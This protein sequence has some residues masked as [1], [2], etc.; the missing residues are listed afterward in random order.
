LIKSLRKNSEIRHCR[1]GHEFHSCRKA[2]LVHGGFQP[3]GESR[4]RS[5][6][7]TS[8]ELDELLVEALASRQLTETEFW[9][10]VTK[11]TDALLAQHKIVS[12]P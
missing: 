10:A 11:Q 2:I 6:A 8:D 1:E 5:F 4:Q 12:R 9:N 3:L 7:G